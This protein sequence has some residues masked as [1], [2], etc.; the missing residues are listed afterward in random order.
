MNHREIVKTYG[1]EKKSYNERYTFYKDNSPWELYKF[2][3]KREYDNG[4]SYLGDAEAIEIWYRV[5]KLGQPLNEAVKEMAEDILS[6]YEGEEIPC[7]LSYIA[8]MCDM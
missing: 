8:K 5:A 2:F 7:E 6:E 3:K 1:L 4:T